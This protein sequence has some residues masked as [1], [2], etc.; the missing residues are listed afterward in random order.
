MTADSLYGV[1]YTSIL[2]L[3]KERGVTANEKGLF[4]LACMKGD[5]LRFSA[6]GFR[7]KVY[8]VPEDIK[9]RYFNLVQLMTQDTFFLP[10]TIIRPIP[11]DFDY[12]FKYWDVADDQYTIAKR[13][14]NKQALLRLM[15]TLP[16]SG[17][18]NQ[19]YQQ[20]QQARDLSYYGQAKPM[21]IMNPFKWAEFINAWKR[22]DFRKKN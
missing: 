1:P 21:N 8:V 5:T 12:A 7:S 11:D 6:V 14:T 19:S 10:E 22:G 3:N 2:V 15:Y 16:K 13:N 18:E 20:M 9:G 17:A 4:S